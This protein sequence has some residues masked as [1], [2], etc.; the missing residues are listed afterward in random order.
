M[1]TPAAFLR[2]VS[3][4][5]LAATV[6]LPAAAQV[7]LTRFVWIGDSLGAGFSAN[8]LTKRVQVDSPSAII[9]RAN[10]VADFQQPII[11]DPGLG[12]CMV[13]TSLAPSFGYEAGNG[14]PANLA[15]PRPYN[16]LS[17]PGCAIGDMLRATT[18]ANRGGCS[19]LID[20]ILRN[21]SLNLG[22]EVDQA[23]ALN[24]TFVVLENAGN[25]Y[26]GAVT[27]GTVIDG[28]TVTPLASFTTDINAALAKL[29]AKV[30]NG[31]VTGVADVTSLP[32]TTTLPPFLTSGGKL[33]LVGGAPIPLLGPKGCPTGVTACPIPATTIVTLNAAGYLPSGF[34]IPCAVAPTLPNCNKPLPASAIDATHPGA[35]IYAADVAFL[36]QRGA[37]YNAAIKAAAAVNG[38]KYYDLNDLLLRLKAGFDYGGATINA[39]FLTGGA[40]SYDGVHPTPIGYAIWADDMVKFINANFPGSNLK[41]PDLSVYIFAGGTAGGLSGPFTGSYAWAPMNDAEKAMAIEQI[42]TLDFASRL[43]AMFSFSKPALVQ[44]DSG[45]VPRIEPHRRGVENQ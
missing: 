14:T 7:D 21:S 2:L 6:A 5:A 44:G 3:A 41:E 4:A 36:K 35:L 39:S 31:V 32:F 30:P 19:A 23:L 15:L 8:C 27:S 16:N 24:P 33:V 43:A 34:G 10:G 9:A 42:F 11:N 37:D 28:V 20:L 45:L 13:L 29:K 18:A 40:F 17:I 12:N 1:K 25:D 22:S 38:Y 26:L